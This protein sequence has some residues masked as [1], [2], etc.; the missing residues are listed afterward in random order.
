ME[1][2]HKVSVIRRFSHRTHKEMETISG[3]Q[4]NFSYN[5][6]KNCFAIA[7]GATQSFYSSI[8]SK[9]LVDYFC[10]NPE[11]DKNNWQK[12]L[13]P[14]QKE[15]LE[16]VTAE[17]KTAKSGNNPAWIEI[18]NRL[19]RFESATSTFIGLQF[20]ENQAKVSIVGDSCLFIFRGNQLIKTYLLE[21]STDFNNQ[22]GYFGSR[23]K[24]NDHEPEFLDIKLKYKQHSDK[25]YFVLA[26]DALAEYIFKYTEQRRDILTTLLKINP[27]QEFDINSQQEF[28]N[29]VTSARHDNTI[30]MKNDDVTL[31]ILEV[32]DREIVSLPTK[33]RKENKEDSSIVLPSSDETEQLSKEDKSNPSNVEE[34][35]Q[36]NTS[37]ETL[38]VPSG[39][40]KIRS[41]IQTLL[42]PL[43][44]LPIMRP[45]PT[46]EVSASISQPTKKRVIKPIDGIRNLLF[47]FIP[48]NIFLSA[49]TLYLIVQTAN[50]INSI[51]TEQSS[52]LNSFSQVTKYEPKYMNLEKGNKIYKDQTFQEIIIPALSDSS[53][54]LILEEGEEWIKFQIDL[55]A[56]QAILNECST[57]A[58]DEIEIKPKTNLRIFPS[59]SEGDVFGQLSEPSKFK[60]LEFD[61]LPNWSKFTF[62]GYVKK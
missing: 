60:K 58:R 44:S 49:T 57:C 38:G 55:Y 30:K 43:Q 62:V 10:G 4:D 48:L 20:I 33:P 46:I 37:D 56:N 54:V 7:D 61:S 47:V 19:N 25:L 50:K 3:C 32:S 27:Q 36:Y 6:A 59:G 14:I 31:M 51:K 35:T 1:S 24:N 34:K 12:W 29:F 53:Q 8:W 39:F 11:I 5:E 40:A 21:K 9:L 13:K 23:S 15:W 22:P 52:N 41:N 28:E 2:H 17:L 18:E 16:R 45:N 42:K 26:T